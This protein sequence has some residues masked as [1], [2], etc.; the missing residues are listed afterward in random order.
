MLKDRNSVEMCVG[1]SVRYF[2][3]SLTDRMLVSLKLSEDTGVIVSI[4]EDNL[5]LI[6]VEFDSDIRDILWFDVIVNK[7]E[8]N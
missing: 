2:R 7:G 4:D 8:D 6:S 3:R 1:D 5:P